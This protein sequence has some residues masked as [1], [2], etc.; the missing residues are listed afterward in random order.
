MTENPF[1]K[2]INSMPGNLHLTPGRIL[3]NDPN[4]P[5]CIHEEDSLTLQQAGNFRLLRIKPY[6]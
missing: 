6:G 1:R 5:A 2:R 3:R 4:L